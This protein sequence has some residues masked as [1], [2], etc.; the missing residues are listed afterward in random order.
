MD[1]EI[2][3][4]FDWSEVV[5]RNGED[6]EFGAC[7]EN[8]AW[9]PH[10]NPLH[11]FSSLSNAF[12]SESNSLRLLLQHPSGN[13]NARQYQQRGRALFAGVWYCD[14][15]WAIL[16]NPRYAT[17]VAASELRSI[18]RNKGKDS[19]IE[20]RLGSLFESSPTVLWRELD[21]DFYTE[22][23]AGSR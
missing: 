22:N 7:H 5:D 15:K 12:D 2:E 6:V 4:E 14:S 18:S 21:E 10:S 23:I 17:L 19:S 3:L 8:Y 9:R 11:K 1:R 20:A 13:V 16:C